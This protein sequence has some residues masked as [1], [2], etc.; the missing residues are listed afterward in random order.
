M[1]SGYVDSKDSK[2]CNAA[3]WSIP[4][5]T[6]CYGR[7]VDF[8]VN[9]P[10]GERWINKFPENTCL[11]SKADQRASR[12]IHVSQEVWWIINILPC[13]SR[14]HKFRYGTWPTP[15]RKGKPWNASQ[16]C[17]YNSQSPRKE[18]VITL[19]AKDTY[20]SC[21]LG[22]RGSIDPAAGRVV[23]VQYNLR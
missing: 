15:C 13:R 12:F 9:G 14:I 23:Q 22:Q 10:L 4:D 8:L 2:L 18:D 11:P 19:W 3:A 5:A 7:E 17:W 21:K 1:P 16:T 6:S 20:I